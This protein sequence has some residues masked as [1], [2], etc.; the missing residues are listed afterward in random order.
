MLKETKELMDLANPVWRINNLYYIK[1]A[2]GHKIKFQMNWAQKELYDNL[3]NFNIILKARQLGITTFFCIYLLDKV[4]WNENIQSGIIAHTL[5]AAQNVFQDKLKFAFDQLHPA[6]RKLFRTVG[7]SAK[8]LA[9]SNGSIIRVGTSLRSST[10]QY[11]HISEFGK[12]CAQS[13]EK[14]REVVT[15]SLNTVHAGQHIYM[16]STAEGKEGAYHTM[17]QKSWTHHLSG[18]PYGP[19]DFKPFFFPWWKEPSYS[20]G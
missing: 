9:F 19:L 14:A 3:H 18:K 20:L 11:L 4:L 13:P 6:I 2:H 7:D 1:N 16:E 17:W 15:G 10:L 5:D 12:I 8:E